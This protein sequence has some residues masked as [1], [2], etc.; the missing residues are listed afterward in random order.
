MYICEYIFHVSVYL[1]NHLFVYLFLNLYTHSFMI[2][3][4]FVGSC[5]CVHAS[6]C[7]LKEKLIQVVR[8]KECRN[9]KRGRQMKCYRLKSQTENIETDRQTQRKNKRG[10]T[11][12]GGVS[13]IRSRISSHKEAKTRNEDRGKR[14]S[15]IAIPSYSIIFI[16][17]KSIVY[18]V[19]VVIV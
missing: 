2:I 11:P 13:T 3:P 9:I 17:I 15:I 6:M 18:T 1:C 7:Y 5:L 12:S 16:I 14:T 4:S 8:E 10:A 19:T